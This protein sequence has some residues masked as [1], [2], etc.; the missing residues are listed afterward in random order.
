MMGSEILQVEKLDKYYGD[1]RALNS[2][3]FQIHPGEIIGLLGHNGAGK[4]T[5]IKCLM[6]AVKSYTGDILISGRNIKH[7]HSAIVD[8][9]GFLLEPSFC[10]YLSAQ[11]NLELLSSVVAKTDRAKVAE[12]LETV[13]L[14]KFSRK[15]V[16]EFS[17]GMRQRLGLAQ[18][19]LTNPQ[20][21]ILDEP[22]VGLDPLGVEII[23]NIIIECSRRNVAVLFSSHQIND[24]FDI[25]HR[26]I[27]MNEG[28]IVYDGPASKLN[29][30][31]YIVRCRTDV[32]QFASI[33]KRYDPELQVKDKEIQFV[34]QDAINDVLRFLLS[35]NLE[36]D[37]FYCENSMNE[38]MNLMKR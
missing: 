15:K 34:Q 24:V 28:N 35:H 13:S 36:I 33:L 19:L 4:S 18:V 27:V 30:K 12:V 22:T 38:L 2:I 16:G 37:D 17:F 3:S 23:K 32:N 9:V 14:K 8:N 20:L 31:Q 29:Q 5:L 21:I 11:I 7:D 6:G 25:C 10:D 26:T 1:L